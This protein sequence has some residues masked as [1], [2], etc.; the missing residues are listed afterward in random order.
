ML[1][2]AGITGEVALRPYYYALR[3]EA[4]KIHSSSCIVCIQGANTT[5]STPML[6]K[7]WFPERFERVAESLSKNYKLYQV[8]MPGETDIP[9]ARDM[10]G[11]LSIQGT[12]ELLAQSRFFIGQ[13]GFLMHLARAVGTR[14]VIVY[15]GR[16]KAWQS[17]YP[18]NENLESSLPCS[19]CWQNNNCDFSRRCQDEIGI[20]E[21]LDAV[22]RLEVRI[23]EELETDRIE[24]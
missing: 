10:R 14:S 21:V 22:H 5:S 19:P 1:K 15:G 24:I 17:G 7:Q 4:R 8:G 11:R 12:A 6:N 13:V 20:G 9:S 3:N 16:E 2:C 23:G 18:C